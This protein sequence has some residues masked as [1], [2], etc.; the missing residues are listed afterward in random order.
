MRELPRARPPRVPPALVAAGLFLLVPLVLTWPLAARIG[1][2]VPNDLGDPLLLVRTLA[3]NAATLPLS[4]GWWSP[5]FFHPL[6]DAI[7][8]T[9][10]LL[11]LSLIASPLQWLGLSPLAAY[12]VTYLCSWWLSGLA[13]WLLCRAL[14]GRDDAALVGG[15]A[16]VLA[17]YRFSQT[18]HLQILATWWLPLM[19]LALHR[20]REAPTWRAAAFVAG[21][22]LLQGL[23]A[24]YYLVYG[25]V[26][27]AAWMVWFARGPG[28]ARLWARVLACGVVAGLLLVPLLLPYRATYDALGLSWSIGEIRD[29]SADVLGLVRADSGLWMWSRV[30][31]PLAAEE[32]LFPGLAI[33]AL[34][35][36]ALW[37]RGPWTVPAWPLSTLLL[38]VAVAAQLAAA[39][40]MLAPGRVHVFG[41]TFISI[42]N[43]LK[44]LTVMVW[45]LLL[46][47]ACSRPVREGWKHRDT[48]MGYALIVAVAFVVA[49]GPT[50]TVAGV[51]IWYQAP[52]AWVVNWPGF[53]ELRVPARMWMY[54]TLGLAVLAAYGFARIRASGL[55]VL[56]AGLVA[57]VVVEGL[58]AVPLFAPPDDVAVPPDVRAV[59]ELPAGDP[60]VDLRAMY[61]Q[62]SHHVPVVNGYSGHYPPAYIQLVMALQRGDALR[63]WVLAR[64]VGPL[65]IVVNRD[66]PESGW[67]ADLA[68]RAGARCGAEATLTVCRLDATAVPAP[69]PAPAP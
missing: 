6:P 39:L 52:Y 49:L 38:G 40:A 48:A 41:V 55:K 56:A 43:A 14:T 27:M 13:A 2:A 42:T 17:P 36:V 24:A 61:R 31:P 32:Q 53:A 29:L 9:D 30:L 15:L 25:L 57:C 67:W 50:P 18:A 22:W 23:S 62:L 12:D 21:C 1:T 19:F 16:F 5:P 3:W 64:D 54:A 59:I 69:A 44:P 8:F 60:A 11:G 33:V 47:L 63:L 26:A 10:H 37:H 7:T 46:A 68:E 20:A 35:V 28:Q 45:A 66:R 58:G 34:S 65:A 4:P 51:P